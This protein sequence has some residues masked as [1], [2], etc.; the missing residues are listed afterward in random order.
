LTQAAASVGWR[1][2][3]LRN[4]SYPSLLPYAD[5]GLEGQRLFPV[6]VARG[7]SVGL[8]LR[9][10]LLVVHAA[11]GVWGIKSL[12]GLDVA[13]SLSLGLFSQR[14]YVAVHE[15]PFKR[16]KVLGVEAE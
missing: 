12:I 10:K 6:D 1:D 15:K 16:R 11:V 2:E 5:F 7:I 9:R 3:T 13:W 8:L 4:F 14:E